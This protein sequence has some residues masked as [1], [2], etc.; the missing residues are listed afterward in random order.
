MPALTQDQ[1]I[2]HVLKCFSD[3]GATEADLQVEGAKLTSDQMY[4]SSWISTTL[5]IL[6]CA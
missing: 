5:A 4:L 2:A 6:E 1:A 3:M